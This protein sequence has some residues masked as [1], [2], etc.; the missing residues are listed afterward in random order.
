[1]KIKVEKVT[2]PKQYKKVTPNFIYNRFDLFLKPDKF[3]AAAITGD[4]G[5]KIVE[6]RLKDKAIELGL[7]LTPITLEELERLIQFICK[8]HP[9]VEKITYKNGVLPYGKAKEHNHFRIKFPKTVEEMEQRVT[10]RSRYK[11]RKK[12]RFAEEAYG[13]MNLTE[14]TR[15]TLPLE[16]VE[17]FFDFKRQTR[18]REYNMTPKKYLSK[19]HVSHCY[20]LSF[21]DTIGAIRFSCEQCPVVYGENFAYNPALKEYSLGRFI[22]YHHLIRMVEKGHSEL[23]FAGGDYEYKTHYGSIEETLYDCTIMVDDLEYTTFFDWNSFCKRTKR[24]LRELFK[25]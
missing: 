25:K 20:V 12:L 21:G 13:E 17:A 1:M 6:Y 4:D 8:Q 23:F 11:M 5:V 19:Y 14:Y 7:W 10:A 2:D 16:I 3:E 15:K 24:K 9:D 22:F 18:G